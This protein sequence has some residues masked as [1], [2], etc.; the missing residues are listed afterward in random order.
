MKPILW[1]VYRLLCLQMPSSPRPWRRQT[2]STGVGLLQMQGLTRQLPAELHPQ[3][4]RLW[5]ICYK[6]PGHS[7][8]ALSPLLLQASWPQSGGPDPLI[9]ANFFRQASLKNISACRQATTSLCRSSSHSWA[10]PK[11]LQATRALPVS[12][13]AA[14]HCSPAGFRQLRWHAAQSTGAL[15]PK[16]I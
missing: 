2:P 5:R 1:R 6:P 11:E 4:W 12:M 3:A 14:Q 13:K 8:V 15:A 9:M 7:Q 16:D 10:A